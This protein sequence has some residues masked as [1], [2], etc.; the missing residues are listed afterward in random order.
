M[1]ALYEIVLSETAEQNAHLADVEIRYKDVSENEEDKSVKNFVNNDPNPDA[2]TTFISC[3]AE[4]ALFLRNSEY[5]GTA[6]FDNVLTRL[7]SIYAY[8]S[9]DYFKT[10]F[11]SLVQKAKTI[12]QK[13]DSFE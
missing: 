12:Y 8:T 7:S 10:E 5:K 13:I 11:F 3:V 2:Q 9:A 1:V 6:S 4:Y